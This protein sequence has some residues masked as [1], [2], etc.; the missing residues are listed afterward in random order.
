MFYSSFKPH[1]KTLSQCLPLSLR[2]PCLP[3]PSFDKGPNDSAVLHKPPKGPNVEPKMDII[4]KF[5][6]MGVLFNEEN[7]PEN[8]SI[9]I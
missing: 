5:P 8:D 1:I 6:A 4:L 3:F 2:K 7:N 9:M